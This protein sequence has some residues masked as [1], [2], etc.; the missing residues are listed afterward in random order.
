M[1]RRYLAIVNDRTRCARDHDAT[2]AGVER[3]RARHRAAI[4]AR[5]TDS[6]GANAIVVRSRSRPVVAGIRDIAG[7]GEHATGL[8][9]AYWASRRR[10]RYCRLWLPYVPPSIAGPRTFTW[11]RNDPEEIGT[12]PRNPRSAAAGSCSRIPNTGSVPFS[13]MIVLYY[14]ERTVKR[15]D[16]GAA[17]LPD[18]NGAV[19]VKI[20]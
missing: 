11:A 5:Y 10:W 18:G 4:L 16:T 9:K 15:T 14:C 6:A 20:A 2:G 7:R 17:H 3:L 12:A 8:A 1:G 13:L 19:I